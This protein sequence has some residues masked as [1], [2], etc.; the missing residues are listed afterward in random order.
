MSP[1]RQTALGQRPRVLLNAA[2]VRVGGGIQ[3]AAAFIGSVLEDPAGIDWSFAVSG[4]LADALAGLGIDPARPEMTTLG[5]GPARSLAV[6][7]R[8]V[9]LP[10]QLD[11]M[12]VFTFFG[13]AYV[14]F[15]RPHL[16][17]VADGW[18][19]H[20]DALAY[21][22][23]P[24]PVARARR[25]LMCRYKAYWFRQADAWVTEAEVAREGLCRRIGC[26]PSAVS[27]VPN[28]CGPRYLDGGDGRVL[29]PPSR[30][31]RILCFSAYYRHKHLE[32]IPEVA[33][34]LRTLG[35]VPPFEFVLTLSDRREVRDLLGQAARLGV[36]DAL[37]NIGPVALG[38]GPAL[39]RSCDL[40]FQPSL[41]ETFSSS[42]PEAM[43]MGIPLVV[44][45]RTFARS[46]CADAALYFDP[47]NPEAA[48][49]TLAQILA[50]GALGECLVAA[51]RRRLTAFGSPTDKQRRLL[52]VVHRFLSGGPGVRH[53]GV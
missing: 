44:S 24:G 35:S 19:T 27:V 7:R 47:L 46:I 51:G 43:A 12:A 33:A 8:L 18:V 22:A 15:Y 40:A 52:D 42:Y 39:Y 29:L 11:A 3:A 23:L 28:T 9:F 26:A 6:R 41:L 48:A 16:C 45:D 34:R 25:R 32:V 37:V 21:G 31:R 14:R 5:G 4:A 49:A 53:S 1:A 20:A 36:G 50:D 10:R 30:R 13:P 17:G 2:T 38:D